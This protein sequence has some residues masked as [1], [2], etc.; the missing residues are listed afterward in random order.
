MSYI[1]SDDNGEFFRIDTALF[2]RTRCSAAQNRLLN[3]ANASKLAQE[4]WP[5]ILA[6]FSL[7]DHLR[8]I[9]ILSPADC[10]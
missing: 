1:T 3:R 4:V 5:S 9:K 10:F 6:N 2:A 8:P 7:A